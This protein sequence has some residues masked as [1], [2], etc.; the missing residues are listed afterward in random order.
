MSTGA[1][2]SVVMGH[3][4]AR[5]LTRLRVHGR[6][7]SALPV[8]LGCTGLLGAAVLAG[9]LVPHWQA[10]AR[11]AD[12]AWQQRVAQMRAAQARPA[13]AG[14]D[15]RL[16]EALPPAGQTP[17]RLAELLALARQHGLVLGS[18]QQSSAQAGDGVGSQP[19]GWHVSGHYLSL[20][21]FVAE[22]LQADPALVLTQLRLSRTDS[23]SPVLQAD[24]QWQLLHRAEQAGPAPA[25]AAR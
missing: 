20:R 15:Q 2:L 5:A 3:V 11:A 19:L 24:L 9:A 4:L 7:R 1:G 12:H 8:A 6:R 10:Q 17:R 16:R 23:R 25:E 18:L 13:T 14:A 22:A 21:Q